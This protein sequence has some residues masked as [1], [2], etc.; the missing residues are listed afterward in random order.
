M[1]IH[2]VLI[3]LAFLAGPYWNSVVYV[4]L[5]SAVFLGIKYISLYIQIMWE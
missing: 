4:T 1:I 3:G 2:D 5:S